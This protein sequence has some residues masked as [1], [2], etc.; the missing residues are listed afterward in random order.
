[1]IGVHQE[2]KGAGSS[3]NYIPGSMSD[4][5]KDVETAQGL[6]QDERPGTAP[7][8]VREVVEGLGVAR[9]THWGVYSWEVPYSDLGF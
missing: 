3:G 4:M 1:M 7:G 9:I 5:N 6:Y 8:R 2:D